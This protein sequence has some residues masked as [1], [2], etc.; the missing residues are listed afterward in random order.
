MMHPQQQQLTQKISGWGCVVMV[1]SFF[2]FLTISGIFSSPLLDLL[3]T[4]LKKSQNT[5]KRSE[6]VFPQAFWNISSF[7]VFQ[8]RVTMNFCLPG[9]QYFIPSSADFMSSFLAEPWCD[10]SSSG[11]TWEMHL[12]HSEIAKR[13]G[14]LNSVIRSVWASCGVFAGVVQSFHL[15][16]FE[17]QTEI[18]S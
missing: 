13:K 14:G 12:C 7:L 15:G 18:R 8:E 1:H 5:F 17:G 3:K 10:M 11:L 4:C 9:G 2:L 16:A 6:V